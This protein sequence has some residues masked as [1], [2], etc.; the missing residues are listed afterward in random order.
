[1]RVAHID[2]LDALP[3]WRR[4]PFDRLLVAQAL[5]EECALVSRDAVLAR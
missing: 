1:M 3:E 4:D 2:H 5:A